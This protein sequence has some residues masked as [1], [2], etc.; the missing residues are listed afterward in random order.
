[1]TKFNRFF[2]LCSIILTTSFEVLGQSDTTML[3]QRAKFLVAA[4]GYISPKID[5]VQFLDQH[6][7]I[8]EL[9]ASGFGKAR[10]LLLKYR[11]GNNDDIPDSLFKLNEV[12]YNCDY[13]IVAHSGLIFRLKGFLN[14][15]FFSFM[16]EFSETSDIGYLLKA[17]VFSLKNIA[18]FK[19]KISSDGIF[20][21]DLD[22]LC[23]YTYYKAQNKA[24]LKTN[25]LPCLGSCTIKDRKRPYQLK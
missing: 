9:K 16:T 4:E 19:K 25:K 8:K 11:M 6:I 24:D 3:Y 7:S 20:I 2:I 15:D 13:I 12:Y 23:L 10:F 14:N 17:N 5:L 22:M 18:T 1:M 21:E